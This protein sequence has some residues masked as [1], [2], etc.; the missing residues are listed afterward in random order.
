MD[1]L[2]AATLAVFAGSIVEGIL[3]FGCSLVWMSFFPL[4]TS[5]PDAVGVLQPMHI[6]LNV[7][8]LSSM[9]RRCSPK[10]LKPLALTV[11]FG[12]V[13]GLWI[14]TSWSSNAIDCVLGL[15]LIVYTFLKSDDDGH[16]H[17]NGGGTDPLS[18]DVAIKMGVKN[19]NHSARKRSDL[20][21]SMGESDFGEEKK[22]D[23]NIMPSLLSPNVSP[24]VEEVPYP[25]LQMSPLT[26][27]HP[28]G[29]VEA[30]TALDHISLPST[31]NSSGSNNAIHQT[32]THNLFQNNQQTPPNV[33]LL[34]KPDMLRNPTAISAGLAGGALMGAF[35]TGGPAFLIY[36]KE[37]GWQRRPELFRANLQLLFFAINVPVCLSQ[38]LEGIIT[39]ERCKAS[40]CL[41]PALVGGGYVGGLLAKKV[42]RDRFE[43]LVVNG[44]R[45][46]G[47]MFLIEA[48]R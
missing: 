14:V 47:L 45:I 17:H 16:G 5:V 21:L 13:F 2:V 3:G 18:R 6:A 24:K 36:A 9:W 11:P 40:C 37:A 38:F 29:V 1:H 34:P 30:G 4:F 20:E 19:G 31:H 10:E 32:G 44:L 35:G 41:L 22:D 28:A 12:I 23:F 42:P 46:M 15:F 7:F 43:I 48:T 26:H 8:F 25:S 33:V 27:R 39:Y